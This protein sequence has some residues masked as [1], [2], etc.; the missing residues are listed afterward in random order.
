MYLHDRFL[1]LTYTCRILPFARLG[2]GTENDKREW[3]LSAVL[4]GDADDA[5]V[6]DV[7]V[8][9]EMAFEFRR[10]D[11]EPSDL[12]KFLDAVNHEYLLVFVESDFI[13]G[14]EPSISSITVNGCPVRC[15]RNNATKQRE[16]AP[17]LE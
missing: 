9:E 12:D 5:R 1:D 6:S 2:I 4:V 10:R 15:V 14:P 8:V 13:A 17:V 11:L 3:F 7:G 16:N